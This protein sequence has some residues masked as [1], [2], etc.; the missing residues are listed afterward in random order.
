MKL[1]AFL[2]AASGVVHTSPRQFFE[3]DYIAA[4]QRMRKDRASIHSVCQKYS[5]DERLVCSMVFPEYIRYS[6]LSGLFETTSLELLYVEYGTK[7][8]DFSVGRFQMKPSFV[9][10]LEKK[11]DPSLVGKYQD[12]LVLTSSQEKNRRTRVNQLKTIEGQCLYACAFIETCIK[13][14]ALDTLPQCEQLKFIATVYNKGLQFDRQDIE[15]AMAKQTF[16]HG[17]KYKEQQFAYWEIAL[18]H[19]LKH[20][21]YEKA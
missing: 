3:S 17:A 11:L 6:Y 12:I 5:V 8:A 19:Y 20:R 16:P 7:A 10:T 14:Y 15:T 2:I 21:K 4:E 9:E 1:I 13:K 18:D